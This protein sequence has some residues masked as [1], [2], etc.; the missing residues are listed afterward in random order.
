MADYRV[1]DSARTAAEQI[2]TQYTPPNHKLW[3]EGH[4]GFQYYLEK[5]GGQPL[6]VRAVLAPAGG[7]CRCPFGQFQLR[8]RFRPAAWD[9]STICSIRRIRGSICRLASASESGGFY[10]SAIGPVPFAVGKVD[11]HVYC[12]VKVLSKVQ[13]N[14]QARQ[15]SGNASRCFTG[16]YPDLLLGG[17]GIC[18]SGKTRC[19]QGDT[20]GGP[21]SNGRRYPGGNSALP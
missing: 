19:G 11:P 17:A 9:G 16:R 20:T 6:D 5:L 10:S 2:A 1:A 3:F 12:L 13:F 4:W 21:E 8:A 18:L 15:P 7:C 14:A